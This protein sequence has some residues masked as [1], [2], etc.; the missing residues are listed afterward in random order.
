MSINDNNSLDNEK[1]RKVKR[2]S[3]ITIALNLLVPG[4][5]LI[6]IG[7][8]KNGILLF[9]GAMFFVVIT[10]WELVINFPF[11]HINVVIALMF[12]VCFYV[13]LIVLSIKETRKTDGF[14][15]KWYNKWYIYII[16]VLLT[17]FIVFPSFQFM[18]NKIMFQ[19][20]ASRSHLSKIGPGDR[21]V[22]DKL[23]YQFSQPKLGDYVLFSPELNIDEVYIG[24][25]VGEPGDKLQIQDGT[26]TITAREGNHFYKAIN[27]PGEDTQSSISNG[28]YY[29]SYNNIDGYFLPYNGL[30][31]KELIKGKVAV[32]YWSYDNSKNSI[33][34][35]KIGMKLGK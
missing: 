20:F 30:I 31:E 11:E 8:A 22:A 12:V 15:P 25:I 19:T 14:F 3:L 7:S 35:E 23:V 34:W 17:N 4:L 16:L 27:I 9:F 26:I 21:F 6:Y 28:F 1:R 24:R 32:I 13:S 33:S 2:Y 10:S 18:L 5:G 29:I